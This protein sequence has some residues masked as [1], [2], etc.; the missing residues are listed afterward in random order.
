MT[1]PPPSGPASFNFGDIW[2]AVAD[3]VPDRVALVWPSGRLTYAEVDLRARSLAAHFAS[4]GV[5]PGDA[6][7]VMM[8]NRP[9][10]VIALI[11]LYLLRARPVNINYRL[12]AR[13]LAYLL[14]DA[15]MVGLVAEPPF[16][17]VMRVALADTASTAWLLATGEPFDLAC[18]N[19]P[20]PRS[21]VDR[22][23][24]DGYL[25][26]T[27]GTTGLPKGVLWRMEDAYFGCL[28]GG[29]PTGTLGP[30]G[31]PAHVTARLVKD[32]AFLPAA[33]LMH[34]AGTWTMLRWLFAGSK[35][36]L[37]PEFD[38][39]AIWSAVA[40]EQVVVM[41]IVGDAM[42]R[43]LV[44]ALEGRSAADG[45]SLRTL[46]SGGASLTGRNKRDLLRLLPHL[47]I[48]D[49]Y[50]SS[51]TGVHGWS[52]YTVETDLESAVPF[53]TRDTILIDPDDGQSFTEAD[54][55]GLVARTGRVPLEY[56]KDPTKSLATFREVDGNRIA[57]TGD[58]GRF[59]GDGTLVLVGRGSNCINSG[60]EKIHPEEVEA[61]LREH[62]SVRDTV[63]LGAPDD[64]WGQRVEAIVALN[65]ADEATEQQLRD[66]CRDRLAAFKVPKRVHL[67]QAVARS[68]AGK[69]DYKWAAAFLER[70]DHASS[71]GT[72]ETA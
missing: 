17:D 39:S 35:V 34:A 6:V 64:R 3:A 48:K 42:A 59:T 50:G 37:L 11:A 65:T 9:E 14:E 18:A 1:S 16:G 7:G 33:P 47:T 62:P 8:L 51:E 36:V 68:A 5:S 4:R 2:E 27:G 49:S 25:L 46:A 71:P 61:V 30:V 66:H 57:I 69:P 29:D 53:T 22:S 41:N 38:P 43:P 60:G 31:T 20:L 19:E 58:L 32:H 55:T 28:G 63:V 54:R 70:A 13:E 44:E 15:E 72:R 45:A 67:A 12:R 40:R 24:N 23:G 56:W 26:Y 10:H 52:E 21:A